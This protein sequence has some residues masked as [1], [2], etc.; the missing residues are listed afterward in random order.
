MILP[1]RRVLPW[2][3]RAMTEQPQQLAAPVLA[4]SGCGAL[5]AG[6]RACAGVVQSGGGRV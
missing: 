3:A 1:R 2:E 4:M 5:G 6:E